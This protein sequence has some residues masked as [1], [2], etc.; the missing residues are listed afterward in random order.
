MPRDTVDFASL[1]SFS[2]TIKK[3]IILHSSR[4]FSFMFYCMYLVFVL[5]FVSF[6][7]YFLAFLSDPRNMPFVLFILYMYLSILCAYVLK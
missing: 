7:M 2:R 4:S 5:V 1:T 3:L 6:I